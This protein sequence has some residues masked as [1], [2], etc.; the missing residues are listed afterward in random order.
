MIYLKSIGLVV[1]LCVVLS[2]RLSVEMKTEQE[3]TYLS[4]IEA[5]KKPVR[6]ITYKSMTKTL[7]EKE[8]M[9][10][11]GRFDKQSK[12]LPTWKQECSVLNLFT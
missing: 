7:L 6:S 9:N 8:P 5:S 1:P 11:T 12:I 3:L 4:L 2:P 10:K